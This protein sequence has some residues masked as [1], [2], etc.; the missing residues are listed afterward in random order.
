MN[1][2]LTEHSRVRALIVDDSAMTRKVLTMGLSTD[3]LIEVVGAA[4]SADQAFDMIREL[5]PDVMTLDVEMPRMDGVSF[6]RKLMPEIQLPT[7]IISSTTLR[8][9][10]ITLQAL[11]AGAVDIIAKPTIGVGGGLQA[12]MADI[13]QRV[14]NAARARPSAQGKVVHIARDLRPAS[15]L[16]PAL[17]AI[18]ASTGGVQ[19][20][21]HVLQ[22]MPANSPGIVIV[23]HM[24]EGFTQAFAKR[25]DTMCAM[26]IREA[27]D[28]DAI[29]AGLALIAPGGTRHMT[30]A[31]PAP[32]W[33]V[34]LIEGEPVCFSRP[35]VDV[36]FESVARLAGAKA[37]AAL[38]TGMGRDG[39]NG[40]LAIRRAGGTTIA[41][42]EATSIVWGMPAAA[43][44][45][46]AAQSVL[47][48][49]GI[50]QALMA[51]NAH[52]VAP[53]L[54]AKYSQ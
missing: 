29:R 51:R 21:T 43:V 18:G 38:L 30:I 35:S 3:P 13:C 47:P 40:M 37:T 44:E 16:Q 28:G 33:R 50:P 12:I 9:A 26:E 45:L 19:A 31:G 27:V 42:D 20:L 4:A 6:L 48:L 49:D 8:G 41:Q 23:Q 39:A 34:S 52:N 24:P 22:E 17:I 5:R 1:P 15:P 46:G 54:A 36:M 11:E 14:R 10:S 25:L 7:V 32:H 53:A 2:H